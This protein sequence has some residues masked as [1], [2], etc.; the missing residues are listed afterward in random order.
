MGDGRNNISSRM[1]RVIHSVGE[2][3]KCFVFKEEPPAKTQ[4]TF[5]PAFDYNSLQDVSATYSSSLYDHH[6]HFDDVTESNYKRIPANTVLKKL[7]AL[8]LRDKAL[9]ASAAAQSVTEVSVNVDELK[10]TVGTCPDMCPE[11]ERLLRIVGNM[12]SSFECRKFNEPAPELMVKAYARSS[13]DQANPLPH[14]LRPTSVLVKT[15]NYM[16]RYIIEPTVEGNDDDNNGD[17]RDLAGWYDF[18]WDRLRAIRKD[19]VQQNLYNRRV[20]TVL[21]QIGRFHI[22]CYDLMLGHPGFD[23]KLNTENLNNCIQMLMPAYRKTAG[24]SASLEN[25]D[26]YDDVDDQNEG[27]QM[28]QNTDFHS[29]EPEFVA[30][31]LLVHLGNPQFYTA[32]DLLP[33]HVKRTARVRFCVRAHLA[34]LQTADCRQ[35]F[36]LLQS[37]NFMNCCILERIIPAIRYNTLRTINTAYT[38][39]KRTCRLDVEHV[40]SRLCFDNADEAFD[41]CR[42]VGLRCVD[43]DGGDTSYIELSRQANLCAPEAVYSTTTSMTGKRQESVIVQKRRDLTRLIA[44]QDL[45]PDPIITAVHSSFNEIDCLISIDSDG[46]YGDNE[47]DQQDC[48]DLKKVIVDQEDGDYVDDDGCDVS[49]RFMDDD[50]VYE[51]EMMNDDDNEFPY[52]INQEN[53]V[54]E[55]NFETMSQDVNNDRVCSKILENE[56]PTFTF[57]LPAFKHVVTPLPQL[58]TPTSGQKLFVNSSDSETRSKRTRTPSVGRVSKNYDLFPQDTS[59]SILS[60]NTTDVLLQTD[61]CSNSSK[62][63]SQRQDVSLSKSMQQLQNN[64]AEITLNLSDEKNINDQSKTKNQIQIYLANKY[65]FRWR[66]RVVMA[67]KTVSKNTLNLVGVDSDRNINV[68]SIAK[69]VTLV[70]SVPEL[71]KRWTIRQRRLAQNYFYQWLRKTL[72]KQRKLA[73]EPFEIEPVIGLPWSVFMRVHGTPKEVIQRSLAAAQIRAS[74]QE[75]QQQSKKQ[76]AS[77]GTSNDISVGIADMFVKN[78]FSSVQQNHESINDVKLSNKKIFW[79]VA[80]NYG[81]EITDGG[82][83]PILDKVHAVLYGIA[84]LSNCQPQAIYMSDHCRWFIK[85]VHSA[86]GL[87][88]WT[89]SGLSAAII[90]TAVDKEPTENFFKRL[91]SILQSTAEP[92]PVAIIFSSSSYSDCAKDG[93]TSK[94]TNSASTTHFVTDYA[95]ILDAFVENEYVTRYCLYRWQGP[96]TILQALDFFSLNYVDAAPGL[97]AEKLYYNL[98]RFAEAFYSMERQRII[99]NT[100]T[101]ESTSSDYDRPFNPNNTVEKFNKLISVYAKRLCSD[102]NKTLRYLAPEFIPYYTSTDPNKFCHKYSNLNANFFERSLNSARL[103]P[104]DPWPPRDLDTLIEYVKLACRLTDR[105]CWCLD[106][107]QTLG[108]DRRECTT[109]SYLLPYAEQWLPVIETWIQGALEKCCAAYDFIVLYDGDPIADVLQMQIL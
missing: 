63:I 109:G 95:S 32:Y 60:S 86:V 11:K 90:F 16:L 55:N 33:D 43:S 69:S 76:I 64:S 77:S 12:V 31:E 82:R 13:A 107:L 97:K 88:N 79:K 49:D 35:F 26:S 105:R 23:V 8:E 93:E 42:A 19:I 84:G 66:R 9:R 29:N 50:E 56:T 83:H 48:H 24:N 78:I 37:T 6:Q 98:M 4:R 14:E 40:M 91:Y 30:Y 17:G 74:T 94:T 45:L 81:E 87:Q 54:R 103:P 1:K 22:A 106:M 92:I 52:D 102:G 15:M 57:K 21:E 58:E 38:T 89:G 72:R 53:D 7:Q 96:Q 75:T 3:D 67:T 36:H 51:H 59:F 34:Y 71:P 61:L 5:S 80:V 73:A 2:E 39:T 100:M 108:L 104:C 70:E 47:D 46:H 18:C 25:N 41:F 27:E 65:F 28:E 101:T 20:V 62:E 10:P 44:G 85:S 99:M 68:R